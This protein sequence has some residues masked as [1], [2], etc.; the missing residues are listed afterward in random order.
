MPKPNRRLGRGLSSLVSGDL[1]PANPAKAADAKQLPAAAPVSTMLTS[2][3][4]PSMAH[5]LLTIPVDGIRRNPMQPRKHFDPAQLSTLADSLKQ[6]GT[7]QPV[8]VRPIEGGYELVAGERRLRAS[9]LA[10]L[11]EIPAI[12]RSV[13][14]D[15]LLELALIENIHRADLNPVERAKAYRLLHVEH[16]LSHDEIGRRVGEDRAT[17]A[18]YIRL[19]NLQEQILSMVASGELTTGHAKAI[20]GS[21]DP[22]KQLEIAKCVVKENWSVRR[23]EA[24]VAREKS[25]G[26]KKPKNEKRPAVADMEQ[27]LTAAIGTRV[28]IQE[29]RRRYAGKITI[30]YYNLDDFERITRLLGVE[31]EGA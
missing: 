18:N 5:R 24:E 31:L 1:T 14:D 4:K 15:Q 10:G 22:N 6:R 13:P 2:G 30:E 23:T 25:E 9:R 27:R 3:E 28:V 19:L 8:V 17:V 29:G 21:E 12:V 26:S 7:L 11:S 16:S 20:L